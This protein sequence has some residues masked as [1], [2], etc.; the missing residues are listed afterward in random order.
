M[1]EEQVIEPF[2]KWLAV[3]YRQSTNKYYYLAKNCDYPLYTRRQL[4]EKFLST[5]TERPT[6]N[7]W[8]A[9]DEDIRLYTEDLRKWEEENNHQ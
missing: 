8:R 9:T 3:N 7:Y 2:K 4:L 5:H 1:T 6:M